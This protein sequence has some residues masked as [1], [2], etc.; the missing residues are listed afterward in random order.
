[1]ASIREHRLQ[2]SSLQFGRKLLTA[3]ALFQLPFLIEIVLRQTG[4][5]GSWQMPGKITSLLWLSTSLL[6]IVG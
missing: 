4:V 6:A 5:L 3:A 2:K 1:M